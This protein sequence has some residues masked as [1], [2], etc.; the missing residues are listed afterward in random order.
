MA[1]DR[2]RLHDKLLSILGLPNVYFQPP[3]TVLLKYPCIIYSTAVRKPKYADDIPYDLQM[4]YSVTVIDSN[5]DS[6]FPDK[7]AELPKCTFDRHYT[8]NNLNHDVFT[9]FY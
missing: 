2:L 5:P 3:A 9:L 1:K 7:L 6:V 8:S 4:G